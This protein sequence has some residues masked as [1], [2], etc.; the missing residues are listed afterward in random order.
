[1]SDFIK[2]FE[3]AKR[4]LKSGEY[5][6]VLQRLI[7]NNRSAERI[8]LIVY[9]IGTNGSYALDLCVKYGITVDG[10]CDTYKTGQYG[11]H[12]ILSAETLKERYANALVVITSRD[13]Y[14]EIWESLILR[15]FAPMQLLR[16]S[17]PGIYRCTLSE[18]ESEHLDGFSAIYDYFNATQ[19]SHSE[20]C[21]GGACAAD[22][23]SAQMV[24]KM[25]KYILLDEPVCEVMLNQLSVKPFNSGI[26][27]EDD[28]V[29]V[30]GGGYDGDTVLSI[31]QRYRDAGKR[32]KKIFSFECDEN[33][34]EKLCAN[35]ANFSNV[36]PVFSGLHSSSGILQFSANTNAGSSFIHNTSK[37]IEMSVTS[38]DEFFSAMPESEWPTLVKLNIEG[39]ESDAIIGMR[40]IIRIK[41][42][43]L[44]IVLHHKVDD[45]YTIPNA[46]MS[47]RS[48]YT[49]R[50]CAEHIADNDVVLYAY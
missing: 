34:Y 6:P 11:A 13:Y 22:E 20:F 39:S 3:E 38:L 40:N 35:V 50:L 8:P 18:F 10:I 32:I 1:L 12:P 19:N 17:G 42:P 4:K 23:D 44:C 47:I 9:G 41:K 7:D 37:M 15:G 33:N 30:D 5:I 16:Y 48:D 49:L 31:L 45:V 26:H 46:V 21:V 36:R 28:D 2:A 29:I 24:I 27:P 43:G 14:E 25:M